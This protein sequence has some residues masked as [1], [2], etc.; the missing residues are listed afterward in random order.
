MLFQ[1]HP[2]L[3]SMERDL[4]STAHLILVFTLYCNLRLALLDN[5]A[6]VKESISFLFFKFHFSLI[7][8]SH[9]SSLLRS[10]HRKLIFDSQAHSPSA[11]HTIEWAHQFLVVASNEHVCVEDAGHGQGMLNTWNNQ[12]VMTLISSH[13]VL[14]IKNIAF[15][16]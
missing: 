3:C 1:Q 13:T 7:L 14:G 5:L 9:M 8:S 11:A 6:D 4:R 10:I 16:L 12:T 2:A 15:Q